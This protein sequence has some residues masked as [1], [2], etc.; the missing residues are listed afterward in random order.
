MIEMSKNS[1]SIGGSLFDRL[2]GQVTGQFVLTWLIFNWPI[3]LEVM[4]G[5]DSSDRIASI[6]GYL[7]G[8][9]FFGLGGRVC[10]PALLTAV[11]LWLIPRIRNWHEEYVNRMTA[12]VKLKEM[13]LKRELSEIELYGSSCRAIAE[14]YS[15]QMVELLTVVDGVAESMAKMKP[16]PRTFLSDQMHVLKAAT[17]AARRLD[18][19]FQGKL[20]QQSTYSLD[21]LRSNLDRST[22][23]R[24]RLIESAEVLPAGT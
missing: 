12:V 21:H 14:M 4:F 22:Q 24:T 20:S 18:E 23:A 10:I 8:E 5:G 6:R 16:G 9:D 15:K 1:D 11:Y 2:G 17:T 3:T 13:D 7:S 19:H